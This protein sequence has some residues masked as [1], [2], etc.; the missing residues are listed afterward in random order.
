MRKRTKLKKKV[1]TNP[2]ISSKIMSIEQSISESHSKE[3]LYDET[4]AVT[5]IKSDP[6]FFFRYAKKFSIWTKAIGTLLHPVTHLLTDNKTEMYTILLDQFNSVFS[7][8]KPNM[9]ISDPVSSLANQ[10]L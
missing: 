8:P 1:H 5:R 10:F 9:I 4:L 7:T 3:K 2:S 6:N